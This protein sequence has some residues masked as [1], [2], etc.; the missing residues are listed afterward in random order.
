MFTVNMNTL[1]KHFGNE[2][3][4]LDAKVFRLTLI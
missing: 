4:A 3:M 1:T 2:E